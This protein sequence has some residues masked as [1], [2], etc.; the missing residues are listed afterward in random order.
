VLLAHRVYMALQRLVI[1][2]A[3]LVYLLIQSPHTL[4]LLHTRHLGVL[5]AISCSELLAVVL[6][7]VRLAG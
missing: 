1:G 2:A 6:F 4:S 7:L 3:S 5:L